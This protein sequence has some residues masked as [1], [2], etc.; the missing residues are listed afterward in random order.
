MVHSEFCCFESIENT[1]TKIAGNVI[2]EE[3]RHR[4]HASLK[5]EGYLQKRAGHSKIRWNIRYFKLQNERLWWCR[6]TFA[7]QL[8]LKAPRRERVAVRDLDLRMV[9]RVYRSKGK[10]PYSTHV[11]A[12]FPDYTL[13]LRA[14]KESV[15]M[16][17]FRIL[18][19]FVLRRDSGTSESHAEAVF[20]RRGSRGFKRRSGREQLTCR[21]V[22]VEMAQTVE[23]K[24]K[25]YLNGG[26]AVECSS[27]EEY[28]AA[29]NARM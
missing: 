29:R 8:R 3:E 26:I 9:T 17:W 28:E 25:V 27:V 6:P 7:E 11:L 13:E 21:R 15:M 19:Q 22:T 16:E 14:E 4:R 20:G 2:H 12:Q 23:K 24:S 5:A 1:P 18:S 10:F